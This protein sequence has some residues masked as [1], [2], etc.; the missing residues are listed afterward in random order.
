MRP[1]PGRIETE[2]ILR[3]LDEDRPPLRLQCGSALVGVPSGAYS[4]D[5]DCIRGIRSDLA[6]FRGKTVQVSFTHRDRGF[7][8][9]GVA[10]P[11]GEDSC[12]FRIPADLFR[13]GEIDAGE[14]CSVSFF[15]GSLAVRAVAVP[16]LPLD[17]VFGIDDR[18]LTRK[19][20]LESLARSSGFPEDNE[21]LLG[22]LNET[23]E[24]VRSNGFEGVM[25]SGGCAV[26]LDHRYVMALVPALENLSANRDRIPV[27]IQY[28]KRAVS[29]V[30]RFIGALR[31]NAALV[32]VCL[33]I[34][35]AQ[36]ED[37]RF[38]YESLYSDLY[39]G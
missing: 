14:L 11:D 36:E 28:G 27:E 5:G 7:F 13:I 10:E 33:E 22:R 37:K 15:L 8:F 29:A 3:T 20:A 1:S 30:S 21:A 39:T 2:Y 12:R 16:S 4:V 34:T 25:R 23:L 35:E 9:S 19:S 17:S 31:V 38:L 32:I 18:N 26:F 24:L 6:S